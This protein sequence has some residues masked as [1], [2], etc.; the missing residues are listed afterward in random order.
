MLIH[1]TYLKLFCSFFSFDMLAKL[2]WY[3]CAL[4]L[5]F[6]SFMDQVFLFWH[7]YLDKWPTHLLNKQQYVIFQDCVN[8]FKRF[9]NNS[10]ISHKKYV[11]ITMWFGLRKRPYTVVLYISVFKN[12]LTYIKKYIFGF[13]FSYIQT[14]GTNYFTNWSVEDGS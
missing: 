10:F 1:C 14:T 5:F 7:W 9:Y 3:S 2:M 11:F 13:A 8:I 6:L 4:V 12:N